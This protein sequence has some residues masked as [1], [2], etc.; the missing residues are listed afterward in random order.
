MEVL[1][2]NLLL[3]IAVLGRWRVSRRLGR[4]AG[5]GRVARSALGGVGRVAGSSLGG[6]GWRLLLAIHVAGLQE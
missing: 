2:T 3:L 4:V 1:L 6:V 5:G